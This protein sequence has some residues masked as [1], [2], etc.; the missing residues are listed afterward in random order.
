MASTHRPSLPSNRQVLLPPALLLALLLLLLATLE[1]VQGRLAPNLRH[2]GSIASAVLI[3][4]LGVV[5][6]LLIA[7][8]QR[9]IRAPLRELERL[10]LTDPLTGLG[11]RRAFQRDLEFRL[12]HATRTGESVALLYLDVDGLKALNDLHGHGCGDETLRTMGAV[13]RSS[14]RAGSDSA[15]RVGGD[16]FVMVLSADREGA[17]CIANRVERG[18]FERS[19]RSSRVSHG[20]VLW[21]GQASAGDLVDRA[22]ER[23]YRDKHRLSVG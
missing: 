18:F 1:L 21:D 8:E 15:Y 5:I 14:T 19:P 2:L 16:E 4:V 20:L 13:L 17:E 6:L 3:V 22:D 7:R 23:M 9:L 10:T 12:R 11:N